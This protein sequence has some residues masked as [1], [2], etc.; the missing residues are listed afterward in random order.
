MCLALGFANSQARK[1]HEKKAAQRASQHPRPVMVKTS[2]ETS[3]PPTSIKVPAPVGPNADSTTSEQESRP[4]K[5][6]S[7]TWPQSR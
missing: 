4:D 2:S 5:R 7:A 1:H 6:N 3:L